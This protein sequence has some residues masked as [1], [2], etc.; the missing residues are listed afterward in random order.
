M[1]KLFSFSS[2]LHEKKVLFLSLLRWHYT[3]D[4]TMRIQCTIFCYT[5]F[6]NSSLLISD[7]ANGA[8]EDP[9]NQTCASDIWMRTKVKINH[10]D[11]KTETFIRV[12]KK[13]PVRISVKSKG[14]KCFSIQ[15]TVSKGTPKNVFRRAKET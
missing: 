3:T 13:P 6:F 2:S 12:E 7:M 15:K 1:S 9:K 10:T 8:K 14:R 11:T 5:R 4:L